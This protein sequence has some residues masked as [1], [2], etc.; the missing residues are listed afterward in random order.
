M[1]NPEQASHAADAP[2][3]SAYRFASIGGRR[4][5]YLDVGEGFPVVL[6]HSYL[7]DAQMWRPQIEA[8]SRHFRV[9]VPELWGH[10]RS[11]APPPGTTDLEHLAAHH[12]ALLDILDIEECHLVG[13]S[14][15]GMWGEA[16]AQRAPQRVR[17]LVLMDT[18][19]GAEPA[20]SQ[21]RYFGMLDMIEREGVIP[22]QVID[23]VV[24]LFFHPAA[25][26]DSPLVTTFRASLQ[27]FSPQQLVEGIVPMG[28]IIFGREDQLARL[29]RLDEER[30]LVTVGEGDI[31]RPLEEARAMAEIIRCPF[32]SV[33]KAG[34]IASL[35]NPAA[36]NRIL[37]DFLLGD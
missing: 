18:F 12:L 7:W 26:L 30:T 9:I 24:P 14:A 28:R 23:A 3:T 33:P 2:R 11:E 37:L 29:G 27:A 32:K 5:A 4:L 8:L 34:H 17:K 20:P 35:E 25:D 15:G 16:L 31:P 10:G 21:I 13:L 6:G 22:P 1:N 36:V 19:V